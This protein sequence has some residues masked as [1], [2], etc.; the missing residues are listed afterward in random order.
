M[1]DQHT[2]PVLSAPLHRRRF[3]HTLGTVGGAALLSTVGLPARVHAAKKEIR[4]LNNE[5]DPNTIAFLKQMATDYEAVSSVK[6][7]IETVPVLDTWTKVTTAIK[8]GKPY[9]FITFG[10]ITEP[11]LLAKDNLLVPLTAI[12]KEIGEQDFGPRA[13]DWYRNELWMYPYDYN[14]NYLI[15]RTDWFKEKNL[16]PPTDWHGFLRLLETL[17]DPA[18]KRYAITLPFS[19]GG[20]TNWGNTAFLWAA[21]VKIYDDQWNVILDSPEIKPKVVRTLEFLVRVTQ[22]TPPGTLET[23]L[24]EMLIN[25]TSGLSAIT[26]YTGRLI[27]TIEDRAPELADKYGIMAYPSPDGGRTTVTFANDGFSIGK[28][29]NSDE[30]LKFFRWFLTNGKLID[31]QLTVPLHYQPPQFSTY[32]NERWRAH[33]LVKKHWAAMEVMLSF[34]NTDKTHVGS[35]QLE[36]PGPSPNQGRIWTENVLPKMYQNVLTKQMNASQAVDAAAQEIRKFT[37]KG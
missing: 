25:F 11:L 29:D 3:L 16:Q 4:F 13:L 37:E 20:H 7:Q 21:G 26:S 36:G 19:S 28:T 8:A 33:P 15:Y 5:T 10:Q 12:I 23:S 22:Y 18:N 34:M 9:D 1:A 35:I 24:K 32:K 27:H 2:V 14:F 6:I 31:Y 30:A 17:N